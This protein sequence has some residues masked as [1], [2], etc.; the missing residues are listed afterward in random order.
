[1]VRRVATTV[2]EASVVELVEAVDAGVTAVDDD[3]VVGLVGLGVLV[4]A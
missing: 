4:E 1:M 3:D 2:L